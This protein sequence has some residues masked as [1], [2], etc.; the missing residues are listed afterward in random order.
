MTPDRIGFKTL[1]LASQEGLRADVSAKESV[2]E[3]T[4]VRETA[5][6][7]VQLIKDEAQKVIG[8]VLVMLSIALNYSI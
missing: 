8:N 1:Y 4:R 5:E 7:E 2:V 3:L 6:R